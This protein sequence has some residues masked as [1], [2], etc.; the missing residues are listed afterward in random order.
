VSTEHP[1]ELGI[2]PGRLVN[3]GFDNLYFVVLSKTTDS[4]RLL[5]GSDWADGADL[6]IANRSWTRTGQRMRYANWGNGEP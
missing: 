1:L 2:V 5:F 4:N 6:G 3:K